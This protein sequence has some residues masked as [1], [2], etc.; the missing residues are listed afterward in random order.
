MTKSIGCANQRDDKNSSLDIF[1][2]TLSTNDPAKELV[3]KVLLIFKHYQMDFK[4]I[5]CLLQWWGKHEAMFSTVGFLPCQILSIVGSQIET[6][7]IF[8][9]TCIL[10]NLRRCC[11]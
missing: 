11:L 5:K 1:Q 10:T 2:Q 3:T 6:K 9:L 4:D 7:I 8:S